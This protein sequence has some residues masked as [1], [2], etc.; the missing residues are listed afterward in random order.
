MG[1]GE[2]WSQNHTS[3]GDSFTVCCWGFLQPQAAFVKQRGREAQNEEGWDALSVCKAR[4]DVC[5]G[6]LGTFCRPCRPCV[7]GRQRTHG[8]PHARLAV[9]DLLLG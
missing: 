4:G 8:A 7:V 3:E 5:R 2:G 6:S 9:P 1:E